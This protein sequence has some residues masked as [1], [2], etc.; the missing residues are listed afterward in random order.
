MPSPTIISRLVPPDRL[1]EGL[2]LLGVAQGI[3]ERRLGDP[4]RAGGHRWI[5]VDRDVM[6]ARAMSITSLTKASSSGA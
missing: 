1:A 2:S 5:Q 6:P 4:E 3:V